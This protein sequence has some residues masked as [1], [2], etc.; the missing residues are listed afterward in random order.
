M[1]KI[2]HSTDFNELFAILLIDD[3]SD[4]IEAKTYSSALGKSFL[5]TVCAYTNEPGLEGG[6]I[7]IG[8]EKNIYDIYPKYIITGIDDPDSLQQQIVT[9]CRENFSITIHPGIKVI[10]HPQGTT[11]LVFIPEAEAHEKPVFIKSRGHKNGIYR[12]IGPSNQICGPED[13]RILYQLGS[14]Q[15]FEETA[16][17]QSTIEDFDPNAI[18]RYRTE[19]KKVNLMRPNCSSRT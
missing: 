13:L 5:E 6:Y 7:L 18:L 11:I 8:I 12:R 16:V 19:R 17:E 3:E 2:T 4:R 10:T 9:Q 15:R 14:K 1:K